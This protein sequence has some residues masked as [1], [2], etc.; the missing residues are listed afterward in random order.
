MNKSLIALL[1]VVGL[2]VGFGAGFLAF[3]SSPSVGS[4]TPYYAM[5]NQALTNE[6]NAIAAPET[7]WLASSTTFGAQALGAVGSTTS[8]ASTT[9]TVAGATVGDYLEWGQTTS[10][11]GVVLNCSVTAAN[12][13]MCYEQ[14]LSSTNNLSAVTSTVNVLDL[15]KASFVPVVVL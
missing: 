11:A 2:V 12:T 15:P 8:T 7:G 13:A 1:V 5:N 3:R 10:T 4:V 9:I 6:L 14:N